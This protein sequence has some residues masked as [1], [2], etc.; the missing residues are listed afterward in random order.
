MELI[1]EFLQIFKDLLHVAC[2]VDQVG[3]AEVICAFLLSEAWSGHGH[4][5]GLVHHLHAVDE[6]GLLALLLC[7]I[8][9]LLRE[10]DTREAIHGALDLRARHLVHIVEGVRKEGSPLLETVKDRVSLWLVQVN[11]LS[12][13]TADKWW[14]DHEID[15][16]LSDSVRAKLD[17]FKFVENLLGT[18]GQV[19]GLHV[20]TAES[21]LSKHTF[22]YGV[23]WNELYFIV[24]RRTH[25][26]QNT[27]HWQEL[28]ALFVDVLLI[29]LVSHD[30]DVVCVADTDNVLQVF[31]AHDLSC[32]IARVDHDDGAGRDT[33]INSLCDKCLKRLG[34]ETPVPIFVEIVRQELTV[35]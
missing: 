29:D 12:G 26:V 30:Q 13:L 18:I 6:V 24:E 25:L 9:E 23:H 16:D 19:V 3:D 17:R 11:T 4:D 21:T 28:F 31:S 5:A 10:V 7:T 22:R 27:P 20:A 14:V 1:V 32:R 33:V 34:I 2:W 8:D 15:G 35:A